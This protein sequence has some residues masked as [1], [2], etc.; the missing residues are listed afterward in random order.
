MINSLPVS[1]SAERE[2]GIRKVYKDH[3]LLVLFGVTLMAVLG[4]SSVT[5]A[6]P[7]IR[8]ALGVTSTEV[9]LLI[10]IFTLPGIFLTPVLGVLSDRHGRKKILTPALLLFGVAGGACVFARNFELL[11]LLRFL[12][13]MGAAALG[14]LNVT[15]IGDIYSGRERSAAMGYNSSVLS[16]GTASYPGI[17]SPWPSSP[18]R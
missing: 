6:F 4:V 3:N 18:S 8:D 12:Q 11:V 16:I 1:T 5:P 14:T 17:R 10:T 13:G 2:G 15:I 9:G 7:R